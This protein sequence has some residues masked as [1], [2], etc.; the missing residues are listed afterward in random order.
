MN[1]NTQ[2]MFLREC[3]RRLIDEH[4]RDYGRLKKE[5]AAALNLPRSFSMPDN[6][7]LELM[8]AELLLSQWGDE[9]YQQ[10]YRGIM[11]EVTQAMAFLKEFDPRL[12][13]AVLN[14]A[15]HDDVPIVLHLFADRAED[16]MVMLLQ[17]KIPFDEMESSFDYGKHWHRVPGYQFI[18]GSRRVCLWVFP[19][20]AVKQTPRDSDGELVKRANMKKVASLAA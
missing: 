12:V 15:I 3:A 20:E 2:D 16:V 1:I 4:R 10:R 17:N 19:W 6:R 11:Q 5:V 9:E 8:V 14:G 18:A 13:G 7:Q